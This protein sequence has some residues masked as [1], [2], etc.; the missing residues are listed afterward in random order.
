MENTLKMLIEYSQTGAN[1]RIAELKALDKGLSDFG[2]TTTTVTNSTNKLTGA[3]TQTSTVMRQLKTDSGNVVSVVEKTSQVI[4]KNTGIMGSWNKQMN[5]L[6][7]TMVNTFFIL[8]TA[9][10][11]V[12]PIV[13]LTKSFVELEQA[14]YKVAAATGTDM[15]TAMS[16]IIKLSNGTIY[17]TK[18]MGESLLEVA[19][20]GYSLAESFIITQ[21]AGKLALAGFS[22][23]KNATSLLINILSVYNLSASQASYLTE[24]V[25]KAANA[26]TADVETFAT[27]LSYAAGTAYQTNVPL[28]QLVGT[29][30]VLQTAGLKSSKAGTSL[31]A[32]MASLISPSTKGQK[33]FDMLGV[34]LTDANGNTRNSIEIFDELR[35]K[36]DGV[37]NK[38]QIL[39][40]I[41]ET[42]GERAV[43]ALM[44][45]SEAA[46]LSIE[47]LS[48]AMQA[49]SASSADNMATQ[50]ES[51]ANRFE[52][53]TNRI[54]NTIV[55]LGGDG[56][57]IRLVEGFELFIAA[58]E[59]TNTRMDEDVQNIYNYGGAWKALAAVMIPLDWMQHTIGPSIAFLTPDFYK[60][61]NEI[62]EERSK[63]TQQETIL[64]DEL[65][66]AI[67]ENNTVRI[68]NARVAIG[69]NEI[70][71]R[72]QAEQDDLAI[73]WYAAKKAGTA[74]AD[75]LAALKAAYDRQGLI[76]ENAE[77]IAAIDV[78]IA[79]GKEGLLVLDDAQIQKMQQLRKEYEGLAVAQGVILNNA[80]KILDALVTRAQNR[81][82]SP[83]LDEAAKLIDELNALQTGPDSFGE[84]R[85]FGM[86]DRIGETIGIVTD[87]MAKIS[88]LDSQIKEWEKD[89][90][91]QQEVI[92]R[93]KEKLQEAR[94][95]L[96]D[97]KEQ[98][99][100]VRDAINKL[101]NA[102]FTG[103]TDFQKKMTDYER[104]IKRL[105]FEKM[106]GMSA[107]EFINKTMGM[108]NEQIKEFLGTFE[109]VN[110]ET[111]KGEN[112]YDSWRQTV[113][114]F[115][116]ATVKSG[117]ELGMS[118][119]SAVTQYSTLLLSTSRFTDSANQQQSAV[120]L[121]G[122]AYDIYYGGMHDE[123]QYQ[124]DLH[125][126]A[127]NGVYTG[128]QEI[129]AGLE[130]QW[131]AETRL[132][133]SIT[134]QETA[135]ESLQDSLEAA[136][137]VYDAIAENIA[138]AKEEMQAFMDAIYATIAALG[139]LSAAQAGNN[140]AA[141]HSP[142]SLVTGVSDEDWQSEWNRMF[143]DLFGSQLPG[144][145][146]GGIVTRATP[147]IAGEAGPEAI[148][149][150]DKLGS[151]GTNVSIGNISIS[152]VNSSNPSDF[153]YKFAQELKRELRTM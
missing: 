22:D 136:Q 30:G 56:M 135:I 47:E 37:A 76:V 25:A 10:L 3:V 86:V 139:D 13:I 71:K 100:D 99:S 145:A 39:A 69:A 83:M 134:Q 6:R 43:S 55:P 127:T 114:E 28:Q 108:S 98:L 115:I 18:Q 90:R 53:A 23:L 68:Q 59:K 144:M 96:S 5:D 35:V 126:D 123:V 148:I 138:N 85:D 149:P 103:E 11:A 44:V 131:A 48:M 17:S 116:T 7:W 119:S 143:E 21:E 58:M 102:K 38:T 128:T 79:M 66:A 104:Y 36:L 112:S 51:T 142:N 2:K 12:A 101:S 34:S 32:A 92:N 61:M 153:A 95:V 125:E 41:F 1:K 29:L 106:T 80:Q 70:S 109:D 75:T 8:K 110:E 147:V 40:E 16:L 27:A 62:Q 64:Q 122:D 124:I 45:A 133:E 107:F 93:W 152:G 54:K 137:D 118:V 113:Q 140:Y 52:V 42:R 150:L 67:K 49:T 151:M 50:M 19:K 146:T 111:K 78:M 9:Q 88:D 4:Q 57:W 121:L 81:G 20:A 73:I 26:S 97:L 141:T 77:K 130:Q 117:N 84:S 33:A 14:S 60:S 24:I 63:L 89:L 120:G 132:T 65:T 82:R 72:A 94:D 74:D 46:K 31:N 87:Y 15:K 91:A 129:I 105:D